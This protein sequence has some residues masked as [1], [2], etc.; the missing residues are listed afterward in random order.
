MYFEYDPNHSLSLY[1]ATAGS[2]GKQRGL[3]HECA[4]FN[5]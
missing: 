5:F 3:L 2:K 4:C 1:Y